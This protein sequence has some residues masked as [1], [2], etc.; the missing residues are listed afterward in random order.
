[1]KLSGSMASWSEG[2]LSFSPALWNSSLPC[3]SLT[4]SLSLLH[5]YLSFSNNLPLHQTLPDSI[6][7]LGGSQ[8]SQQ[9][10]YYWGGGGITEEFTQLQSCLPLMLNSFQIKRK[11]R[12]IGES[13]RGVV[14][15]KTPYS[16]LCISSKVSS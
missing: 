5:K 3:A 12:E 4:S 10:K 8:K 2:R 9:R 13:S 14:K 7:L 1:M 6:H 15:Y 11:Q 16:S